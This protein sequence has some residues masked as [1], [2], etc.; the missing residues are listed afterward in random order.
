LLLKV[1]ADV[2]A[3]DYFGWTA[4]HRAANVGYEKVVKLLLE[5][6]VAVV[7][8]KNDCEATALHLAAQNGNN[9]V[10]EQLI[11]GNAD[12]E[13]RCCDGWTPLHWAAEHTQKSAFRV[14]FKTQTDIEAKN[15]VILEAPSQISKST[16]YYLDKL[17]ASMKADVKGENP[18][19]YSSRYA[20]W[21]PI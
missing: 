15:S 16:S 14:L 1:K 2:R 19:L 3:K 20:T 9:A 18:S 13:A 17:M 6:D 5:A 8:D 21:E 12:V 7:N 4:L 10:M 11:E